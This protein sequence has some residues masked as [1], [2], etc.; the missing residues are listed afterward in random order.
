MWLSVGLLAFGVA[1]AH[2]APTSVELQHSGDDGLSSKLA[3][4]VL[5]AFQHAPDFAIAPSDQGKLIVRAPATNVG[6]RKVSERVRVNY[7]ADFLGR[8]G[9]VMATGSGDCWEDALSLCAQQ[10]LRAARNT[11]KKSGL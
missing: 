3:D 1:S 5:V 2:A 6:W 11:V 10:I 7:A 8:N 4:E 9:S